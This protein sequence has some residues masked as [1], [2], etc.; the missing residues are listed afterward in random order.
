MASCRWQSITLQQRHSPST[1]EE[2]TSGPVVSQTASPAPTGV[3]PGEDLG[4]PPLGA[5]PGQSN[6]VRA[7]SFTDPLVQDTSHSVRRRSL[8]SSPA[9]AEEANGTATDNCRKFG[10][11]Q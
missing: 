5:S 11:S 10:T 6:P 1:S 8:M 9:N 2:H 4:A 3:P 7:V